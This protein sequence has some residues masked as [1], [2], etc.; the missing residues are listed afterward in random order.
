MSNQDNVETQ[1]MDCLDERMEAITSTDSDEVSILDLVA[2]QNNLHYVLGYLEGSQDQ[3]VATF[4]DIPVEVVQQ[5]INKEL[6][7]A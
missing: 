2:V 7:N 6:R 1:E 5:L 3:S 4:L